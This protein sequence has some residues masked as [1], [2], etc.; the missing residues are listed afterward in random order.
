MVGLDQAKEVFISGSIVD[1]AMIISLLFDM[2]DGEILK[3]LF[4]QE[5]V[6]TSPLVVEGTMIISDWLVKLGELDG[7]Q[8]DDMFITGVIVDAKMN[9]SDWLI[10]G[11]LDC[12]GKLE[13]KNITSSEEDAG[14]SD[15]EVQRTGVVIGNT[16]LLDRPAVNK[17]LLPK[18]SSELLFKVT[19]APIVVDCDIN[20]FVDKVLLLLF[21]LGKSEENMIISSVDVGIIGTEL[22][23]VLNELLKEDE[24]SMGRVDILV[25][26]KDVLFMA[27]I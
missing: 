20:G 13:E 17:S 22:L 15:L 2:E 25:H 14:I 4:A 18:M 27:G 9:D 16:K 8:I 5:L 6:D 23:V 21:S 1:G 7:C 12:D 26:S 3:V 11:L 24:L 10:P 19:L